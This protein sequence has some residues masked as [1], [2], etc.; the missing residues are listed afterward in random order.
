M[1][2]CF[3]IT[4]TFSNVKSYLKRFIFFKDD[5]IIQERLLCISRFAKTTTSAL[6]CSLRAALAS[7]CPTSKDR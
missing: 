1:I 2:F 3:F 7:T 4:S 6:S 5:C